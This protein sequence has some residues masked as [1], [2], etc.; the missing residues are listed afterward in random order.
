M[1]ADIPVPVTDEEIEQMV[2]ALLGERDASSSICPSD[3]AR[4][5]AGEE[6]AWRALMPA[7]RRVAASLAAK[8]TLRVTRGAD[9]VD[10]N[11]PGG[12]VRLRR[13]K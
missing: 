6:H 3:V 2:F 5:L 4:A 12:P 11:L 13:H 10:A 7:V 1:S 8:G 9:E